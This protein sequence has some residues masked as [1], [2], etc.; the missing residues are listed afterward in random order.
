MN[1]KLMSKQKSCQKIR[2]IL[3]HIPGQSGK[4]FA[5]K[6]GDNRIAVSGTGTGP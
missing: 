6:L 2:L 5:E 3:E 1:R 4:E